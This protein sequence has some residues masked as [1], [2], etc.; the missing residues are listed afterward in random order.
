[1]PRKRGAKPDFAI[2]PDTGEEIEGLYVN[3]NK[4][5]RVRYYYFLDETGKQKT[6]TSNIRTAIKRYNAFKEENR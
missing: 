3:R 5:G 2:H 1:M 4:Q 6:C